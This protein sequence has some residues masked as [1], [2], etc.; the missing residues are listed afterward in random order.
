MGREVSR[1]KEMICS[2]KLPSGAICMEK[3]K[4]GSLVILIICKH[5]AFNKLG[6]L[7]QHLIYAVSRS[8]LNLS[9][10]FETGLNLCSN[11]MK[12]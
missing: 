8:C 5:I 3:K 11:P 7:F 12:L 10:V 4:S 6:A 1:K 2:C 9:Q